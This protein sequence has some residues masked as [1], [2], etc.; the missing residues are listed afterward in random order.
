MQLLQIGLLNLKAVEQ[1]LQMRYVLAE[2]KQ[3]LTMK[4]VKKPI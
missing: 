1:G 4:Q 3:P 2:Q